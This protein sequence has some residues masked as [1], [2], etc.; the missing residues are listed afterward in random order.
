MA[1]GI[2]E[3]TEMS[4]VVQIRYVETHTINTGNYSS[5]KVELEGVVE[6]EDGDDAKR[7]YRKL[8]K[9]VEEQLKSQI[10]KHEEVASGKGDK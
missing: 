9:Q 5:V 7:E 10:E 4:K 8:I 3:Q 1:S 2:R 6:L